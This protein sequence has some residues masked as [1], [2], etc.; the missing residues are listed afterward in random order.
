MVH[1][2]NGTG[3]MGEMEEMEEKKMPLQV[4]GSRGV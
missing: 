4:T 2:M 1:V 3:K